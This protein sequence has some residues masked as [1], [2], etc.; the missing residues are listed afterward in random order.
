[1]NKVDVV[2]VVENSSELGPQGVIVP[3]SGLM[4]AFGIHKLLRSGSLERLSVY[5]MNYLAR[6]SGQPVA[7][8]HKPEPRRVVSA[9]ASRSLFSTVLRSFP[10][11]TLFRL[12]LLVFLSLSLSLSPP[13]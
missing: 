9:T 11:T 3:F 6:V 7:L 5:L 4:E 2:V 8:E 1:M 13:S 10:P 12:P